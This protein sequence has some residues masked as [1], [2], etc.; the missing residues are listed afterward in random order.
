MQIGFLLCKGK[1]SKEIAADLIETVQLVKGKYRKLQ[2][3]EHYTC[4]LCLEVN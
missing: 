2:F 1:P 3:I 4:W